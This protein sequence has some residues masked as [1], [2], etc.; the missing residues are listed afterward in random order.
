MET[1]GPAA[2]GHP[3]RDPFGPEA[4]RPRIAAVATATP[5][6]GFTQDEVLALAGYADER[7]QGFF[8]R[9]EVQTRF[10]Y[11][12]E[13]FTPD[14]DLDA[15]QARYARG[16]CEIS[17]AAARRCLA[18]AGASQEDVEFIATTS[19]TG[20]ICPDLDA[21]M[22]KAL[23]L[24]RTV[25][26]AHIGNTGCASALV[27]LQQ[28]CAHVQAYP[29][30]RAL[31]LAA[32]ICSATYYLDDT[33]ETAVSHAIF[34]DGAAALYVTS[35]GPGAEVLGLRTLFFPEHQDK[36]GYT[37]PGGRARINLSKDIRR[38]GGPIIRELVEL[39][40]AD[41][42]LA[43][44]DVRFWVLHSGGRRVIERAQELMGLSDDDV[45]PT[46]KVLRQYG[47]MSSPTVLFVLDEVL[48]SGQPQPGDLAMMVALGPGFAAEGALLRWC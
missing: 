5:A 9:S 27:A 6:R 3:S 26:R 31:V 19:C 28:A 38:I 20:R 7:R 35:E 37:F 42:H 44:K 30:H 32:E 13:G 16:V 10:L 1:A 41:F 34:G 4:C 18:A 24:R 14:E 36:M 46:R 21:L 17:E 43:Q 33:L 15:L 40:L 12:D 8:R 48:R 22:V 29:G 25:Q 39:L 23:G 47:N 11:L 2:L 45:A